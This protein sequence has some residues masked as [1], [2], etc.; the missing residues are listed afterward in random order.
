MSLVSKSCNAAFATALLLALSGCSGHSNTNSGS[1]VLAVSPARL[2]FSANFGQQVDPLPAIIHIANT[3]TGSLTF[4]ASTDA[5]WLAVTPTGGNAPQS[6]QVTAMIGAL[7]PGT[8][9]GH[10]IIKSLGVSGSPATVDVK[11]SISP[12]ILSRRR[13]HVAPDQAS[14]P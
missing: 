13:P 2:S 10:V 9:T 14:A 8:Y 3:G 4:S 6:L 5:A 7:K 11:F 12:P 1:P